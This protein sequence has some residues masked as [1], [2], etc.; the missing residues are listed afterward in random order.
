MAF[1][2]RTVVGL[3][4]LASVV[5][6]SVAEQAFQP[7]H[8]VPITRTVMRDGSIRYGVWI[9]VGARFVEAMLDTGSTGLRVLPPVVPGDLEGLPTA[10][11]YGS[12]VTL[13]GL[14]VPELI[15]IGPL[16]GTV[17]IE[18]VDEATCA[19]DRPQC[20]VSARG[21]AGYLIG[22]DGLSGHGFSAI[23]GIGFTSRGQDIQ[24]PLEVLGAKS[25]IVDV[26]RAEAE[27]G[28]LTVNPDQA[29]QDGFSMAP[30]GKTRD[31]FGCL[32]SKILDEQICGAMLLDTGAPGILAIRDADTPES[33]WTPKTPSVLRFMKGVALPFTVGEKGTPT[34][35]QTL[36]YK[37][38]PAGE[39][40]FILAGLYP[41]LAFDV[42]Y[43]ALAHKVGLKPRDK[44]PSF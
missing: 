28:K 4:M 8:D 5:T 10:V 24:N 2:S 37:A 32:I 3:V 35:V 31:F 26:P 18:V 21:G 29:A 36:P 15:E 27:E 23:L 33:F 1:L 43:D 17:M 38:R 7:S 44:S 34:A 12:G 20:A 39:S 19:P 25:W 30:G 11:T 42:L 22:G 13:K 6:P 41:Y 9:K 14:L 40:P 16:S